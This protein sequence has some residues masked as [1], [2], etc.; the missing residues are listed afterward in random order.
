MS[1]SHGIAIIVA[2]IL[3]DCLEINNSH[4]HSNKVNCCWKTLGR[5]QY[6]NKNIPNENINPRNHEMKLNTTFV[7]YPVQPETLRNCQGRNPA[8]F[9]CRACA[10]WFLRGFWL[11]RIPNTVFFIIVFYYV[12]ICPR[13]ERLW[14]VMVSRRSYPPLA[15]RR[16]PYKRYVCVITQNALHSL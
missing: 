4:V 10:L 11:S 7:R 3:S 15:V 1:L 16:P 6:E 8:S 5:W 13:S 9:G 12:I 2:W 14:N